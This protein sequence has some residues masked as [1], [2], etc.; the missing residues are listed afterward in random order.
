M[1][2]EKVEEKTKIL[3]AWM[4]KNDLESIGQPE[5]ARYNAPITPPFLRRNEVMISYSN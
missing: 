5:L 3:L 1:N 4:Q 2:S